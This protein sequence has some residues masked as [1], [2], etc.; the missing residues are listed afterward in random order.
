MGINMGGRAEVQTIE[1]K[2]A[3]K[4]TVQREFETP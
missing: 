3:S 4:A 2:Y 1:C